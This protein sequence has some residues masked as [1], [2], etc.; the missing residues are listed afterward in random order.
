MKTSQIPKRLNFIIVLFL[1][2]SISCCNK[3]KSQN[4]ATPLSNT[5]LTTLPQDVGG[6]HMPVYLTN[7]NPFGY[8]I[9]TPSGYDNNQASYPLLVFLHGSGQRGNSMTNPDDL[10]KILSYGPPL[11]ISQKRWSPR[12]PMIVASPQ[13][14]QNFDPKLVNDFIKDLI[15]RYRVNTHRIYLTGLSLGGGGI[16]SYLISYSNN[17]YAAAAVPMSGGGFEGNPTVTMYSNISKVPVWAFCGGDDAALPNLL[18]T[19]NAINQLKPTLKTKLTVFPGL[20]HDIW[21]ITYSGSGMGKESRDYDAFNTTI[22]DW[23][24]QYAK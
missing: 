24:F 4:Q 2:F 22:Y 17:G 11:L 9:Y 20:G 10:N 6:T 3:P 7:N 1:F 23:M 13:S 5:D 18:K 19:I 21:D 8:Y 15:S 12:Y 16:M 14:S